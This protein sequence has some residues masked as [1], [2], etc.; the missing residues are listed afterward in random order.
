LHKK[1]GSVGDVKLRGLQ[2]AHVRGMRLIEQRG[3]LAED[4]ARFRHLGDLSAT[5]DDAYLY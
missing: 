2:G 4:H 3:N 1:C 5:L